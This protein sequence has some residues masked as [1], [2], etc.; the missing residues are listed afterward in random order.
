MK[1]EKAIEVL[2]EELETNLFVLGSELDQAQRLGIE[3]LKRE[4]Q[5]RQG[6]ETNSPWLLPGETEE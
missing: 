3:A 6:V 5:H 2:E 4:L 1:L